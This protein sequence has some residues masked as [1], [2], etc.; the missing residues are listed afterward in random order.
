MLLPLP[1][2]PLPSL[3]PPPLPVPVP[4]PLLLPPL[5]PLRRLLLS[6]LCLSLFL[7]NSCFPPLSSPQPQMDQV[8]A[9]PFALGYW[10]T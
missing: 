1:V 8:R 4:L 3:P 5:L 6:G 2:L 7:N 9:L 10:F